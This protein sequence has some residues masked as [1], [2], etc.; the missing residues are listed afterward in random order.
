[1]TLDEMLALLADNTTG[2][3][4]A[5]DM[6]AIVTDLYNAAHSV[7]DSYAYRW[8][9]SGTAPATGHVTMDQPWQTF[10][11]KVLVSEP[12]EDGIGPAF[13]TVDTAAAAKCW[14][15]T[16][17]GSKLEANITGPSVDLGTYREVPI[18]VVSITGPQPANNA[19]VTTT[20]AAII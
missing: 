16:A 14:I 9:T 5:D 15:T 2:A 10:A 4:G 8:S 19:N 18:Q 1:M 3:I 7:G 6:R 12:T 11:T 20:L 13:T 17:S